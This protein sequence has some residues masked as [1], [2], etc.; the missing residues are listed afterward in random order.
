MLIRH[1]FFVG[2]IDEETDLFLTIVAIAMSL[3]I[4]VI[5]CY[6]CYYGLIKPQYRKFKVKF[7]KSQ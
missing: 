3:V 4:V 1:D 5:S 7:A 6:T 2:E